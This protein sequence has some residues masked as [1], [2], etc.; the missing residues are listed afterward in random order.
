MSL[1]WLFGPY[2]TG[3]WSHRSVLLIR[4]SYLDLCQLALL[5]YKRN[6]NP[7]VVQVPCDGPW[8]LWKCHKT[9]SCQFWGKQA[10]KQICASLCAMLGE[11]RRGR[12][13]LIMFGQR[14]GWVEK[15]AGRRFSGWVACGWDCGWMGSWKYR[16]DLKLV[17]YPNPI[18][19][20]HTT[21]L[22][23]LTAIQQQTTAVP[24]LSAGYSTSTRELPVPMHVCSAVKPIV[25]N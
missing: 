5:D 20:Q 10:G 23:C 11:Q 19:E 4:W 24:N 8:V 3:P 2:Q 17:P 7:Q 15:E 22:D 21:V 12:V 1:K 16:W 18:P 14:G 9:L 13:A 25:F 6:P